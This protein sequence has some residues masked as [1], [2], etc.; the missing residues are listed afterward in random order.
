MLR[1]LF[2]RPRFRLF[3]WSFFICL[4]AVALA[5]SLGASIPL[6]F[7]SPWQDS[8]QN[9]SFALRVATTVYGLW[10]VSAYLALPPRVAGS[11]A[12][13]TPLTSLPQ[14]GIALAILYVLTAT[15]DA[16]FMRP[17]F[18]SHHIAD[19]EAGFLATLAG[20]GTPGVVAMRQAVKIMFIAAFAEQQGWHDG[21]GKA[22]RFRA[23][24]SAFAPALVYAAVVPVSVLAV[25]LD[26]A[27]R[28]FAIFDVIVG[29]TLGVYLFWW[30]LVSWGLLVWGEARDQRYAERMMMPTLFFILI[31]MIMGDDLR[32]LGVL[33][34]IAVGTLTVPQLVLRGLR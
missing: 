7:V 26:A 12:S 10:L 15:F 23:Y 8:A 31:P 25:V 5:D 28:G 16:Y 6:A 2:P 33:G 32:R 17:L 22:T 24:H 21:E 29:A 13:A 20:G 34:A 18:Y 4:W 3:C 9:V 1:R 30:F 19:A 11:H 14:P 27:A